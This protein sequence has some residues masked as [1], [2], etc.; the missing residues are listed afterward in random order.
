MHAARMF[1]RVR[2]H[3]KNAHL[4]RMSDGTFCVIRDLGLVKGGKGM[5]H[6][7]VLITLSLKAFYRLIQAR[8][9]LLLRSV[10]PRTDRPDPRQASGSE[11]TNELSAT[12]F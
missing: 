6:H 7:E 12:K 3:F 9:L 5:R 4:A 2:S 11:T 1:A 8:M 10:A